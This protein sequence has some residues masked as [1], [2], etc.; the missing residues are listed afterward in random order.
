LALALSLLLP[1]QEPEPVFR[2][3]TQLVQLTFVALDKNGQPVTDLKREEIVLEDKG[4][5]QEIVFFQF[6]GAGS[7]APPMPRN[8]PKGSFSNRVEVAGGPPRNLTAVVLD[9]LNSAPADMTWVRAQTMRFLRKL[10]PDTRVALYLLGQR[11][12]VLHDFS[13]DMDTLR[14]RLEAATFGLPPLTELNMDTAI[15]E[16]ES[17]LRM[18]GDDPVLEA[19]LRGQ[20]EA[21]QLANAAL[22]ARR[23]EMTLEMLESLGRHLSGIPGRKN[24]VWIGGG[25]S[26]LS[27]TGAMGFGS[28]G[29]TTSYESQVRDSAKRLAQQGITLYNVDSRGLVGPSSFDSSNSGFVI[30]G[31]RRAFGQQQQAEQIS[32][33]PIPAMTAMASVTGGRVILNTND[34]LEGARLAANDL[35]GSYS[36]AFYLTGEPDGKWHALKIRTKRSGV[37]LMHQEGYF[38]EAPAER[39]RSW[40]KEDWTAAMQ[41]PL[42]SSAV[43]LDATCRPAEGEEPG[44]LTVE[45]LL[46]PR[47]LHFQRKEGLLIGQLEM[48]LGEKGAQGLLGYQRI[49]GSLKLPGNTVN[50]PPPEENRLERQWK[51]RPGA[52]SLRVIVRDVFTGRFGSIDIPAKSCAAP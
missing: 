41:N 46:E 31:R 40:G 48:G 18:S 2:T 51:P 52:T 16:A 50:L 49:T 32:A 5:P 6:E 15:A 38:A 35:R 3:T 17:L 27:I 12:A 9:T 47:D 42:G 13:D 19:M 23:L 37:R 1:A 4:K 25:V 20:I 21:D 39:P 43:H 34:P 36:A 24:L 30:P 33:D 10:A 29:G 11:V 28:R 14:K 45:V 7:T 22:R 8:L 26:M 44:V